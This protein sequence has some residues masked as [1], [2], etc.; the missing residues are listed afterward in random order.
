MPK[1][2]VLNQLV[3]D[4][5]LDTDFRISFQAFKSDP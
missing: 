5:R 4:A 1:K 2:N 3:N